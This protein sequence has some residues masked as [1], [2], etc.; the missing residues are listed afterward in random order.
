MKLSGWMFMF[1]SWGVI[2]FLLVSC[3]SRIL[4]KKE[5]K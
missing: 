1:V 3:L 2:I 4:T 5:A